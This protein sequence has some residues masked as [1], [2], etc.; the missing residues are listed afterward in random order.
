MGFNQPH[1]GDNECTASVEAWF[2][3]KFSV[4]EYVAAVEDIFLHPFQLDSEE[5]D[6]YDTPR[7]EWGQKQC[8]RNAYNYQFGNVYEANW[9][10]KLLKSPKM[11]GGSSFDEELDGRKSMVVQGCARLC[12]G[13]GRNINSHLLI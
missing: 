10:T 8:S 12:S 11:R 4:D 2:S 5:D 9:H 7:N 1:F 13:K 6:G 3:S